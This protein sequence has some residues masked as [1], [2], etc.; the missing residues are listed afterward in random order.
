[1]YRRL[2]TLASCQQDACQLKISTGLD[3]FHG[4]EKRDFLPVIA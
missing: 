4:H 2:K 3:E 1:M